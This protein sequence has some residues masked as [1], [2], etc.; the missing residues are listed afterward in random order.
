MSGVGRPR[1]Y[2]LFLQ[3]L[4]DETVYTPATIVSTGEKAGLFQPGHG[5]FEKE[6]TEQCWHRL[7]VCQKRRFKGASFRLGCRGLADGGGN[8]GMAPKT[9]P[10][11]SEA[12]LCYLL[13]KA[14]AK[15]KT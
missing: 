14:E 10:G 13:T 11:T 5:L 15:T 2:N 4:D 8:H 1:K 6:L 9:K 3:I 12:G 7:M